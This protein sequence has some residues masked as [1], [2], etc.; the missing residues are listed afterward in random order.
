MEN[1]DEAGSVMQQQ[2]AFADIFVALSARWSGMLECYVEVCGPFVRDGQR[3]VFA[4][5][6]G[7]GH[8]AFT[9][10]LLNDSNDIDPTVAE[11]ES[12]ILSVRTV[13]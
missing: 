1:H 6:H 9:A 4:Q 13:H 11:L 3:V 10:P 2:M 7:Y 8:E 5:I 12:K